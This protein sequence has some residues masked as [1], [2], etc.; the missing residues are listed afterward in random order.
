MTERFEEFTYLRPDIAEF[1]KN[2]EK[3]L[4]K[5]R[6]AETAD[7][8]LEAFKSLNALIESFNTMK[9]IANVRY[10]IDTR[11][12][13][14]S[15]EH[16]YFNE[17]QPQAMALSQKL[18]R[19]LVNSRFRDEIENRTG[20]QLFSKAEKTIKVYDK[21]IDDELRKES[22]LATSYQKLIA[23]AKIPF[24][25]E[26]RNIAG[27]DPFMQSSD[28]SMRKRANEAK[29]KFFSDNEEEFDRI[30]DELVKVRTAIAHK[31]GYENFVALGY[32]RMN[33]ID[34]GPEQVAKFRRNVKEHIVPAVSVLKELKKK[35]LGIDHAY[36]YDSTFQF[37]D[38]N[39][40][41][42]GDP[43]WIVANAKKMYE[44]LSD[45]TGEFINIMIDRNLMDLDN[46]QGKSAGGYCT[47]LPDHKVPYI[48]ANMNGTS[49]DVRVLTHEAGHAFQA[50]QSRNFEIPQNRHS[51]SET[52]EVHSMGMEY[53]T[54]P[55]MKLFFNE[56][57]GK[58]LLQH[59]TRALGFLPYCVCID[60]FQHFVYENPSASPDERKSKWREIE[61]YYMPLIDYAD[62]DFLQRGGY[63]MHQQHVFRMPFYYID[64][65]LAQ[66]C[67]LQFWKRTSED[68]DKAWADYLK[69]CK[70]GG[71]K[72]FLELVKEAGLESPFADG[73]IESAVAHSMEWIKLNENI[74]V[75]SET[76]K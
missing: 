41:P 22:R 14:Y 73:V 4:D 69:L 21:S 28:R 7:E 72:P 23:S 74:G 3:G 17:V 46:R 25:G 38:G 26:D 63:W 68:R 35:R 42:K 66:I 49:H 36:Y 6:N 43:E 47:F 39:P 2:F 11:D 24:E 20:R 34:Y 30:Y 13:F 57:T 52:A 5:F 53:L 67:A 61:K 40:T 45:E 76:G 12:E 64:Y 19:E 37:P 59:L 48:F 44:E 62:N 29:W 56:D 60:E 33:R 31:L 51:T 71:S 58:F 8:Q 75:P 27:M 16:D 65:G 32:D 18:M 70:L 10:T 9:S 54:W 55:W 15:M 1:Q 50:Y